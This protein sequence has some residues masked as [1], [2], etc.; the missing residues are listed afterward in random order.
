VGENFIA[1]AVGGVIWWR[2]KAGP[3]SGELVLFGSVWSVAI[4]WAVLKTCHIEISLSVEATI[5]YC[6]L[7]MYSKAERTLSMVC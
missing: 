6:C 7:L 2:Q 3:I 1:A 4:G 5:Q